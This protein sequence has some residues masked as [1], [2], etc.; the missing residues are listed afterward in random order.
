M[1]EKVTNPGCQHPWKSKCSEG[2]VPS[3]TIRVEKSQAHNLIVE[4]A[5]ALPC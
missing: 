3:T 4:Y 5:Y 1:T 2:P